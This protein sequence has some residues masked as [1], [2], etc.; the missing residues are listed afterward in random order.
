[1]KKLFFVFLFFYT[2]LTFANDVVEKLCNSLGFYKNSTTYAGCHE[3]FYGKTIDVNTSTELNSQSKKRNNA[4]ANDDVEAL[5][6]SLGFYKNS[7][8]YAGCRERFYAKTI[9]GNTSTELNSQSQKRNNI[10]SRELYGDGSPEHDACEKFG[11]L[12]GTSQYADCRLKIEVSQNELKLNQAR[13]DAEMQQ[14]QDQ[15]AR[16]E[17]EK[18]RKQGDAITKF[19]LSL[20]GGKSPYFVENLANAARESYGLPPVAPVAPRSQ[21]FTI[22]GPSGRL[23]NCEMTGNNINC[24]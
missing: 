16:Y 5:C 23:T 9:E 10:T 20:M 24:F 6:N 7:T 15:I 8:T 13:F 19:G 14:Y 18:Q 2:N 11:F 21:N 3:R 22:T 4:I 12:F 1:M 17:K